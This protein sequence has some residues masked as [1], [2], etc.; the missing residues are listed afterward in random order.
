MS[1]LTK[2]QV[3]NA[4]QPDFDFLLN[5]RGTHLSSRKV[6]CQYMIVHKSTKVYY[7]LVFMDGIDQRCQTLADTTFEGIGRVKAINVIPKGGDFVE[8]PILTDFLATIGIGRMK[9]DGKWRIIF[10]QEIVW[11]ENKSVDN[12]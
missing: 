7:A 3:Y 8:E 10:G 9:Y 6:T 2:T 5:V 11:E 12:Q 4:L 1:E